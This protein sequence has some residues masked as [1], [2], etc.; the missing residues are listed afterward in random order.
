MSVLKL[1]FDKFPNVDV[2]VLEDHLQRA[3]QGPFYQPEYDIES[4]Q[5]TVYRG[6]STTSGWY[7]EFP[8]RTSEHNFSINCGGHKSNQN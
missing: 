7:I 6:E 3:S 1:L 5:G 8:V 2:S 4:G